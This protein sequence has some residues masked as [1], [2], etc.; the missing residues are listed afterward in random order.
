MSW[1]TDLFCNITFYRE[2]FNSKYEVEDKIDEYNTYL[3]MAK[4]RIRNLAYI[5]EPNKF[6]PSE[7]DPLIWISNE[8]R[9]CF[10]SIDEYNVELYKLRLLLD[11]WDKC[12]TDE[13]L[14]INPPADINWDSAFLDGDFIKTIEKPNST[15]ILE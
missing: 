5:T 12:H 15:D 9:D 2:T 4:N 14:A 10:E 1:Q 7:S 11:N 3:E 13:G 8:L 6:C